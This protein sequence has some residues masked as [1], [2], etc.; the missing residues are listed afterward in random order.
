MKIRF[1][2]VVRMSCKLGPEFG[3][4]SNAARYFNAI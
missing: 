1:K 3:P 2:L 4:R